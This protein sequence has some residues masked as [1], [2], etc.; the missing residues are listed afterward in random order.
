LAG[1]GSLKKLFYILLLLGY[2]F[3]LGVS[4][5][6]FAYKHLN[7]LKQLGYTSFVAFDGLL[8]L[9]LSPT[10]SEYYSRK[11]GTYPGGVIYM[12]RN[13]DS[14]LQKRSV[15]GLQ[16]VEGSPDGGIDVCRHT[17]SGK[18]NPGSSRFQYT[19]TAI[20]GLQNG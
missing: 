20:Y 16:S 7:T 5:G 10:D 17:E 3:V 19:C 18:R 2:R 4:L 1:I 11:R 8:N 12:E 6:H 9:N 14:A 15:R 13:F